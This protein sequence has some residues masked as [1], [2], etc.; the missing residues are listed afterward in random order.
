MAP[1]QQ[2]PAEAWASGPPRPPWP[3]PMTRLTMRGVPLPPPCLRTGSTLPE[4]TA[5]SAAFRG[6]R[7]RAAGWPSSTSTART[8]TWHPAGCHRGELA[9]RYTSLLAVMHFGQNTAGGGVWQ[10][11]WLRV[12]LGSRRGRL[13]LVRSPAPPSPLTRNHCPL[14][15]TPSPPS[16]QVHRQVR[17]R[18]G[19]RSCRRRGQRGAGATGGQR[20]LPL[21]QPAAPRRGLRQHLPRS[22][23]A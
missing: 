10:C 17:G 14:P 21:G 6:T 19:G 18:T 2:G 8:C 16:S 11:R 4:P 13:S 23:V 20:G 12:K 5:G 22:D 9:A 1:P 3:Q 7:R 15:P